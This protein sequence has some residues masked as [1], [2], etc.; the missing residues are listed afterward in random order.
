[1]PQPLQHNIIFDDLSA[2]FQSTTTVAGSP[3]TNAETVIATLTFA[4]F[5]DIAVVSGIR[6]RGWCAFT[7]GTSG[8]S[9]RLR[10]KQTNASGTT[11]ADTGLTTVTAANLLEMSI[12]G[13]DV[14]PG[15]GVYALTLIIGSGAAVSTVSA[16][17]L[18][19]DII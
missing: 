15:I 17:S 6:L 12:N 13:F 16:V 3:A 4:N 1:M 10:I 14:A 2:R 18:G 19:A 11:V 7:V 8:V 9:A 5:N